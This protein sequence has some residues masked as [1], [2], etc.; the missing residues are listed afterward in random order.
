V[1]ALSVLVR[2]QGRENTPKGLGEENR[3]NITA[4][5]V[6]MA[7]VDRKLIEEEDYEYACLGAFCGT[8]WTAAKHS[9]L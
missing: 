6:S 4:V 7:T 3:E 8:A 5:A 2:R 9:Q 1:F